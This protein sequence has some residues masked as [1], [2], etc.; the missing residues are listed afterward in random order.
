[1]FPSFSTSNLRPPVQQKVVLKKIVKPA[2]APAPAASPAPTIKL[3]PDANAI[4]Y[5]LIK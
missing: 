1:M 2:P 5:F 3:P 4:H